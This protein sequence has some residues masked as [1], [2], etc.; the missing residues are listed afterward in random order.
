VG[1]GVTAGADDPE[2]GD[3]VPEAPE[4]LGVVVSWL[5]DVGE[6]EEC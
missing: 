5:A 6:L 4:P 2:G 1:D 3:V